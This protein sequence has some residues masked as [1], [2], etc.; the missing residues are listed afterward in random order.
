MSSNP[1][2]PNSSPEFSPAMLHNKRGPLHPESSNPSNKDKTN[3]ATTTNQFLPKTVSNFFQ[4]RRLLVLTCL[5][6]PPLAVFLKTGLSKKF[7]LSLLLFA[8]FLFP[9]NFNFNYIFIFMSVMSV[10]IV[11]IVY[12]FYVT[13]L[14]SALNPSDNS[15][16]V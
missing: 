14:E 3:T 1:P 2:E 4:D 10:I 13:F 8:F 5:F 11:G 9:G 15:Y 12:G 16:Q 6:L 7:V